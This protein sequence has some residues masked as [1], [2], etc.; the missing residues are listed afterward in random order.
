MHIQFADYSSG[1][2]T[3]A[4]KAKADGFNPGGVDTFRTVTFDEWLRL[5]LHVRI[6]HSSQTIV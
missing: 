6:T 2:D 3:I 5:F 1:R 4:R